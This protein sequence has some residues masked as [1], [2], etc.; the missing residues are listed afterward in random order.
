MQGFK[1]FRTVGDVDYFSERTHFCSPAWGV[2]VFNITTT[3]TTT[4]TII[5]IIT[6]SI[7]IAVISN[8]RTR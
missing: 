1:W 4:T 7:I 5:I 6:Q 2:H 3:T 8:V